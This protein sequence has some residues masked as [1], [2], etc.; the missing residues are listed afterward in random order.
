[1]ASANMVTLFSIVQQWP[2]PL[3]N[4]FI[5]R[6]LKYQTRSQGLIETNHSAW[7]RMNTQLSPS[8]I[9]SLKR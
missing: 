2:R 5:S 6:A 7:S 1:M 8:D 9:A 4:I 3:A